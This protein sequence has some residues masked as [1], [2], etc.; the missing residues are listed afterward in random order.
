MVL[1]GLLSSP[2]AAQQVVTLEGAL[3]MALTRNPSLESAEASAAASSSARWADWGAFLPTAR[4]NVSL[5]QTDFTN[6]TFLTPEGSPSIID[7]P[8]TDVSKGSNASLVFGLQLLNPERIA[9]VKA[10]GAR[11]D[12]AYLRLTAAQRTVIRDVKM[13]YFEALKQ[14]QLLDVAERQLVARHADLEVTR[15]RYRIAAASRSD[16]LGAE[17]DASDA[18]LRVLQ[19]EDGLGQAIRGLQVVMADPVSNVAGLV[20][21]VDVENVPDADALDGA[22]LVRAAHESNPTLAALLK[23]EAAATSDLWAARATYLPQI[24]LGF[25]LGRGKQLGRD[26]SLLDF[27]P[28]NTSSTFQIIGSWSLFQ[29]FERK[30]QTALADERITRA[31]ADWTAGTLQLDKEVRDLVQEIQR[32]DARLEILERN[33]NLADERLELARE[34]YRLGS[35]PYFNLQQAI[36]R[37]TQAEQS[38]FTERYDYLI[39]WAQLEE[40]VGPALASGPANAPA[41]P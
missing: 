13:A 10:G 32:R 28:A 39:R 8:L 15:D 40:K 26:E 23:D 19:A 20:T 1:V 24:D 35:I 16:L 14:T 9:N 21:L 25:V 27:E 18:E 2:L 36:D 41:A 33:R 4:A 34:Q 5:S 17:M 12:A 7:P 22:L 6:V 30:R 11:K 3:E 31:R 37:T 38:L 29:G